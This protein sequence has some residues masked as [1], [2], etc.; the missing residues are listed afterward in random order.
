MSNEMAPRGASQ[1][2]ANY[3]NKYELER[4][5][6]ILS[7]KDGTKTKQRIQQYMKL[8][9][10]NDKLQACTPESHIKAVLDCATT[11]LWPGPAGHMYLIPF[12]RTATAI[13]GYKGLIA[14]MKRGR[15]TMVTADLVYENDD[16]T[17]RGQGNEPKHT[18]YFLLGK[19]EPGKFL[20][21]FA[22]AHYNNGD[23]QC[24]LM[25]ADEVGK[26]QNGSPGAKKRDSPWNDVKG[27]GLGEMRKKTAIRRL[28]KLV[29]FDEDDPH[30]QATVDLMDRHDGYDQ[31]LQNV[32]PTYDETTGEVTGS[33]GFLDQARTYDTGPVSE[34]EAEAIRREEAEAAK[35]TA[36]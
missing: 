17:W 27:V 12:G 13:P 15:V 10:R 26:I 6:R 9:E 1:A 32:T 5:R 30:M 36:P 22:V 4:M 7:D 2:L 31:Q 20:A 33:S 34:T 11:D 21:A 24:A 28:Y 18:P 16:F 29:G 35:E 19:E 8:V 25:S 14:R 3:F 23:K